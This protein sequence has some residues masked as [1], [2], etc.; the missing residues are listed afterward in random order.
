MKKNWYLI[1]L[2]VVLIFLL[3]A[4]C[5]VLIFIIGPFP[6]PNGTATPEETCID[7]A[8][9]RTR[10]CDEF[11]ATRDVVRKNGRAEDDRYWHQLRSG[12]TLSTDSSGEAELNVS[13]CWS[14]R[15]WL[16]DDSQ[17]RIRVEGCRKAEYDQLSTLCVP[18]GTLYSGKCR[19]E[20]SLTTGS[21]RVTKLGTSFS[22]TALPDDRDI[23]LVI[24]LQGNVIVQPVRSYD[25]PDLGDGYAMEV[26]GGEFYFTMPDEDLS[27]VGGL[28]SRDAHSVRDLGPVA[29]ELGIVDWLNQVRERAEEEGVLPDNWPDLDEEAEP[30][31]EELGYVVTSGGGKLSDPFIQE[32]L[33]LA[34][35]WQATGPYE[36]GGGETV[37]VYSGDEPVDAIDEL[38]HDPGEAEAMLEEMGYYPDDVVVL[39]P[40]GDER[41]EKA[42]HIVVRDLGFVEVGAAVEAV[43]AWDLDQIMAMRMEAGE[44]TIALSR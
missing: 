32:A 39:Y 1:L 14:G 35:D 30:E 36:P 22:V 24:A 40:E 16:F 15:L 13:D 12:D 29:R 34:I 19:G 8:S 20:F 38:P 23:S 2:L 41:L 10:G 27:R 6:P 26:P 5:V 18:N 33:Y 17:G 9:A 21:V 7:G 25:P 3:V 43:P 42:A 4:A 28:Q 37:T 31:P 44:P 11:T